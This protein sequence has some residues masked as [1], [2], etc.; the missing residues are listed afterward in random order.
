LE[1]AVTVF[2]VN[3]AH[4]QQGPGRQPAKADARWLATRMRHGLLQASCIPAREPR[5]WRDLTRDRPRLVQ[6]RRR[7]GNRV[8]GVLERAPIK[9]AAVAPDIMGGSARALVAALVEGRAELATMAE[10]AKRRRR[11]KRPR[12]EQALTGLVRDQPRP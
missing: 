11:R 5:A 8:P 1:G 6:E 9:L 3:A 7:E 2:P 12:L 4:V 10:L